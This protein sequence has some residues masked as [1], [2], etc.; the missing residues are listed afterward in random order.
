V[1]PGTSRLRLTARADLAE[2]ELGKALAI[3]REAT[4]MP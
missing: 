3:V 4:G 1:P 2:G